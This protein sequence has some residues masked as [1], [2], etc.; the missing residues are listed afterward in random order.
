MA[1]AIGVIVLS[2]RFSNRR[3]K[4]SRHDRPAFLSTTALSLLSFA[5][6]LLINGLFGLFWVGLAFLAFG[7]GVIIWLET[8]WKR[9]DRP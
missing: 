1:I 3:S 7:T 5:G 6:A 9:A 2:Q 8:V 4:A